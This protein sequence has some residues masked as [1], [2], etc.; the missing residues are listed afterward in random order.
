MRHVKEQLKQ[1]RD[2]FSKNRKF[3]AVFVSSIMDMIEQLQDD[4]EQ[5]EKENDWIPITEQLPRQG[6]YVLLSFENYLLP[7]IGF[8]EEDKKGGAFCNAEGYKFNSAGIF[9]NAWMPLPEPYKED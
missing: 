6:A 3:D 8:Y 9:V 2:E 4:L 5:D 1:Y 7:E